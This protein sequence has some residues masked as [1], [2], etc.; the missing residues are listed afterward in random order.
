MSEELQQKQESEII[1]ENEIPESVRKNLPQGAVVRR[2]KRK[3]IKQSETIKDL[4]RETQNRKELAQLQRA[5]QGM[6][7]DESVLENQEEVIGA[8]KTVRGKLEN[9][10]YH[11]KLWVG[12]GAFLALL[13]AVGIHGWFFANQ[14]DVHIVLASEYPLDDPNIHLEEPFTHYTEDYD[15]NHKQEVN[16]E[17]W[18]ILRSGKYESSNRYAN[19]INQFKMAL[20]MGD[21]SPQLYILDQANYD[22]MTNEIDIEFRDLSDL[23]RSGKITG[24]RV[25]ISDTVLA[26]DFPE[27]KQLMKEL[28]LCI[29]DLEQM[30]TD[31]DG[32]PEDKFL[33]N[34]KYMK[35]YNESLAYLTN[36][37]NGDNITI[38]EK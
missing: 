29:Y 33:Q 2:V 17:I 9:F 14:H 19:I 26:K 13:L 35:K 6:D 38:P 15:K 22:Y 8:P 20:A 10:W 25:A 32:K 21:Y 7:V 23:D 3:K 37:I 16:I 27:Y 1:P 12:V 36:V 28:Y 18:Q 30:K 5:R 24:D 31:S 11:K 34:K 4:R